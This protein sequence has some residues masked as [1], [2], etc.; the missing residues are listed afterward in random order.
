MNYQLVLQFATSS[1]ADFDRLIALETKLMERLDEIGVVDGHDFGS[2]TFN[3]FVLTNEPMTAFTQAH[4][5]IL[6]AAI[7]NEM[8]SAYREANG[9]NYVFSGRQPSPSSVSYSTR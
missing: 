1:I 4:Q 5:V 2:G 7:P 6:H 3:I 8:R 9:K